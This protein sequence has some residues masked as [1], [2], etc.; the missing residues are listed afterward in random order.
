MKI[1][2]LFL[3]TLLLAGSFNAFADEKKIPEPFRGDDPDS[4]FEVSYD[5]LDA[6][7]QSLVLDVGR[8]SRKKAPRPQN[9]GTR[10]KSRVNRLTALEGNRFNFDALDDEEVTK[11]L[12]TLQDSLETLPSQ[13]PL[14]LLNRN[15]QLAYWLNLYN[16]TLL[17]ELAKEK[18]TSSVKKL[19][20]YGDED[21]ILAKKVLNVGGVSLS[22]DD[23]QFTI[24]KEKYHDNA[25]VIYGLFQGNIGGPSIQNKA[26]QGSNVWRQLEENAT[27]F[28][29]SNRGTYYDGKISVFY[30][31]NLPF[32]DNS[33]E[34]L[35][36]HLLDFLEDDFYTE[37]MNAK[38]LDFDTADWQIASL[39]GG[40]RD[41]GASGMINNAALLDAVQAKQRI[42][43]G[44]GGVSSVA[45][46]NPL[47]ENVVDMARL[48]TRFPAAQIEVLQRLREMQKINQ[49]KVEIK[50][51]DKEDVKKDIKN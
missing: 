20:D 5:D 42:G 43:G 49:G 13:V 30:E 9:T 45:I 46:E 40:A 14:S 41:F 35:K 22:L 37:I 19:L 12:T 32:F 34:K 10:M 3:S 25:L 50:D 33:K 8:S 1:S 15:E 27:E 16:F 36:E 2:A 24:L 18:P 31:R 26:F 47:G 38:T 23:I 28:V 11:I 21:S 29:N 39:T 6:F 17:D 4:K 7:L 44:S 48:N 51:L